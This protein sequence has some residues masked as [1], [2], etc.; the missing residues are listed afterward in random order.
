MC[1]MADLSREHRL[2]ARS[3]AQIVAMRDSAVSRLANV[4]GLKFRGR[5]LSDEAFINGAILAFLA[6]DNASQVR[7]MG[8]NLRRLESMLEDDGP[9]ESAPM[10]PVD[11]DAAAREIQSQ[12]TESPPKQKR[13][14]NH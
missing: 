12:A 13:K 5:K 10:A 11:M 9:S 7:T 4:S 2:N 6:L 1:R 3:T 14:R 8:D